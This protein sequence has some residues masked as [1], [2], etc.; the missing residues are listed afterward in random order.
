ML[1]PE[2]VQGEKGKGKE[3]QINSVPNS[4]HTGG[5]QI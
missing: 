4:K 3:K 2:K 5:F 1:V